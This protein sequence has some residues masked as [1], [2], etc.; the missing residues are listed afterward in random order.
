MI[1]PKPCT[2][3]QD[4]VIDKA[5]SILAECYALPSIRCQFQA[6]GGAYWRLSTRVPLS[7]STMRLKLEL[8]YHRSG[9]SQE[10]FQK[11]ERVPACSLA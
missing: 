4:S 2:S 11:K 7:T 1:A 8:R 10:A 3:V 6:R 9:S 5:S